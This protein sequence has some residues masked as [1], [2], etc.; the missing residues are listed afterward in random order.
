M[1][2]PWKILWG[3]GWFDWSQPFKK[4]ETEAENMR[5][6]QWMLRSGNVESLSH[7]GTCS[8]PFGDRAVFKEH[9]FPLV[10]EAICLGSPRQEGEIRHTVHSF[11][12]HS[13]IHVS[14]I[15]W[16]PTMCWVLC[17]AGGRVTDN[18]EKCL[19]SSFKVSGTSLSALYALTNLILTRTQW[20]RYSY[21]PHA[22]EEEKWGWRQHNECSQGTD[23]LQRAADWKINDDDGQS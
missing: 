21:Y 4:K 17:L 19:V 22:V 8:P 15:H 23:G 14:N 20:G 3:F 13:W 9:I 11:T 2:S 10:M 18:D 1:G 16:I 6:I 5:E 7:R 12:H